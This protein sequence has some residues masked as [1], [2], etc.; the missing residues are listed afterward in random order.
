[1]S[2]AAHVKAFVDEFVTAVQQR[3]AS[4]AGATAPTQQVALI[5]QQFVA[6]VLPH[7]TN[8]FD[9]TS[10][11]ELNT[12][13]TQYIQHAVVNRPV[14]GVPLLFEDLCN[15]YLNQYQKLAAVAQGLAPAQ[16]V[17]A[18][19]PAKTP[20][21][22]ALC[23]SFVRSL[24]D[25]AR[26]SVGSPRTPQGAAFDEQ[27]YTHL[28][29]ALDNVEKLQDKDAKLHGLVNLVKVVIKA[30]ESY[31]EGA[32]P[33]RSGYT[34]LAF[35]EVTYQVRRAQLSTQLRARCD[36]PRRTSATLCASFPMISSR[37]APGPEL[38]CARLVCV[39]RSQPLPPSR[40]A[41]TPE[42]DRDSG[43]EA[44]RARRGAG[45]GRGVGRR[46]GIGRPGDGE[47]AGRTA[48]L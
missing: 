22:A 6:A 29:A 1:M 20:S 11:H 30:A 36:P 43:G 13:C 4:A 27:Y 24:A 46:G 9:N 8:Y 26:A 15:T 18:V 16:P 34:P 7:L 41:A 5:N 37:P 28:T 2:S 17:S 35:E 45:G 47:P 14:G 38:A 12:M 10:V 32:P 25:V 23:L 42:D 39:L 3:A 31:H 48:Q 19:Q 40:L 33:L 44:A 21:P